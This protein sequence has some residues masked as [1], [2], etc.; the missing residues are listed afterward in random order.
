MYIRAK[1]NHSKTYT[2]LDANTFSLQ[3]TYFP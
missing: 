1:R 3:P 2:A